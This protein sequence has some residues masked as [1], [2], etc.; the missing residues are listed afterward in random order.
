MEKYCTYFC[1]ALG[2]VFLFMAFLIAW[3]YLL[4]SGVCF[5]TAIMTTETREH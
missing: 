4:T 1:I 3:K 5:G 2:V